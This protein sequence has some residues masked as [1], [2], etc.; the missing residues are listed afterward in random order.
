MSTDKQGLDHD[1]VET[2]VTY[3]HERERVMGWTSSKA[4]GNLWV[5][6]YPDETKRGGGYVELNCHMDDFI[7]PKLLK[8]PRVKRELTPEQRAAVSE[9]LQ[10]ARNSRT[11]STV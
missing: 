4:V 5:K 1:P 2:T 6:Q 7:P 8:R 10:R 9:R 11:T 3:D